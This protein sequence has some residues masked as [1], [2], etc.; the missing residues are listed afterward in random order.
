MYKYYFPP[1]PIDGPI[2]PAIPFAHMM[3]SGAV[4]NKCNHC[5][6]MFEGEC[7][8]YMDEVGHYLH[9]DYGPCGIEGPTEPVTIEH[10]GDPSNIEIPKKCATCEYLRGHSSCTKDKDVWGDFNRGLDW[11]QWK[12]EI[13]HIQL[14]F[15]KITTQELN[16]CA[17][18]DDL[19]SFIKEHRRVNPGTSHEEAKKDFKFFRAVLKKHML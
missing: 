8:R 4:P 12:P 15:P 17:H 10:E 16:L 6:Y 3:S 19:I 11:G 5:Q 7:M 1:C 9:L 18:R 14:A 13:I 2:E